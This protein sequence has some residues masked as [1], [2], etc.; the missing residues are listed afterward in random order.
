MADA[1]RRLARVAISISTIADDSLRQHEG[2]ERE[3]QNAD[4]HPRDGG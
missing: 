3:L 4:A 1:L 2:D